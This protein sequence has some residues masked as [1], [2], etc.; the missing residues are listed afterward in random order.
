M[1]VTPWKFEFS[2]PHH[3]SG[4]NSHR[5]AFSEVQPAL[6]AGA[7][8]A[9][10]QD[11]RRRGNRAL[12][13]HD[14]RHSICRR[15]D[16]PC[17][18]TRTASTRPSSRPTIAVCSGDHDES[19]LSPNDRLTIPTASRARQTQ[20]RRLRSFERVLFQAAADHRLQHTP[21]AGLGTSLATDWLQCS[22]PAV[23]CSSSPSRTDAWAASRADCCTASRSHLPDAVVTPRRQSLR[24]RDSRDR[25]E[26]P[27]IASPEE[28]ADARQLGKTAQEQR[29]TRR[30]TQVRGDQ[31]PSM[32]RRD[33]F[34]DNGRQAESWPS[35][36]ATPAFAQYSS[37]GEGKQQ[38]GFWHCA[39]DTRGFLEDSQARG[40]CGV[41]HRLVLRHAG[42]ERRYPC[43]DGCRGSEFGSGSAPVC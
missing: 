19:R 40:G 34:R 33:L 16:I 8:P 21:A 32:V 25:S 12:A 26:G 27:A 1:G 38:D 14:V 2:R 6:G 4:A 7:K 3:S 17:K 10:Q 30:C 15:R 13:V 28:L 37:L 35:H 20:Q 42:S 9:P 31:A 23:P 41:Q 43:R 24:T 11:D 29:A 39:S 22:R 5:R 18:H 36:K